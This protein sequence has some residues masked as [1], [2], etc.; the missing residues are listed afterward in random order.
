[1]LDKAIYDSITSSLKDVLPAFEDVLNAND[2]YY[3]SSRKRSYDGDDSK[4]NKISLRN[5]KLQV[6]V[7][8]AEIRLKKGESYPGGSWHVEGTTNEKIV[9]S[10]VCYTNIQGIY[11][12][13]LAFRKWIDQSTL[14]SY[15]SDFHEPVAEINDVHNSES[16]IKPIGSLQAKK[17]RCIV[18]FNKYQHKV[19]PFTAKSDGMRR[20][21][22]YFLVDPANHISEKKDNSPPLYDMAHF[23]KIIAERKQVHLQSSS[24]FGQFDETIN[25]SIE[26][27]QL[28]MYI[29]GEAE[30]I[31]EFMEQPYA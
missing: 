17:G 24:L 12:S 2:C 20:I 18:F 28:R 29:A 8:I 5:R 6:I 30:R 14:A 15:R 13:R 10:A 11:T 26:D 21:L 1:D 9:A 31:D 25:P 19:L 16:I 23:E 3:Q 22:C 4:H 7:K 27:N